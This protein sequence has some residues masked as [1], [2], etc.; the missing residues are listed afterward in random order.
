MLGRLFGWAVAALHKASFS[1]KQINEFSTSSRMYTIHNYL[2]LSFFN[3]A[4]YCACISSVFKSF[5]AGFTFS[6]LICFHLI[7]MQHQMRKHSTEKI[8]TFKNRL[9]DGFL[10]D[11]F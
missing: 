10:F 11:F 2:P 4:A 1:A 7:E 9:L 5:F 6:H 8:L 3:F